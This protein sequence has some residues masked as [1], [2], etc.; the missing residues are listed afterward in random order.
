VGRVRTRR[1][2][3][4]AWAGDS[5]LGG[6]VQE[7]LPTLLESTQPVMERLDAH[8]RTHNLTE[9]ADIASDVFPQVSAPVCRCRSCSGTDRRVAYRLRGYLVSPNRCPRVS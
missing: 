3:R 4:S 2:S 8:M 7:Y 9:L 5:G 6:Y 1:E